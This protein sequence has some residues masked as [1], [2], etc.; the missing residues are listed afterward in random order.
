MKNKILLILSHILVALTA[1]AITLFVFA[2]QMPQTYSKLDQLEDLIVEKFIGEADKTVMEDAAASAMVD[3]LGD[4]WS[5]YISAEDYDSYMEQMRNAYVGIG[6][7]ILVRE[8]GAG[9][10]V[11]EVAAG[12][13]AEEAGI[14]VGDT[15][16]AV[17]GKSIAGQDTEAVRDQIKGQEGTSVS[18]TVLRGAEELT[19][20]VMRREIQTPVATAQLLEDG[21]GLV[22]IENFDARCAGETTAAIESLMEQG[23]TKLIFDVR[24]NPGGYKSE[25]V[26]LLDYLVPEGPIFRSEYYDGTV[27]DDNSDARELD[28][29]MAVLVNADSYSAAEFFPAALRDYGKAIIVGQQTCGKGYFQN[30]YLLEDGSAVGLSIGKYYTPKGESLADVGITPDVPVE[31]DEET[32]AEIYYGMLEPMEDPQILAAME[33]LKNK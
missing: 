27:E 5:Y 31:V 15:V 7:T 26:D 22:T 14:L 17:E 6:I 25:L 19:L 20:S 2:G 8:D 18:I 21:I 28:V 12:G 4:R 1:T 24:N 23:A 9:L 3:S 10:D 29:P 33:A 13:P 32:Y 11:M 16:I 30:T